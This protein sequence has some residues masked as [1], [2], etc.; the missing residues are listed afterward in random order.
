MSTRSMHRYALGSGQPAI[1][2]HNPPEIT[3]A[4]VVGLSG[5]G[6]PVADH[7]L[8]EPELLALIGGQR[9]RDRIARLMADADT[10]AD[11]ITATKARASRR[12]T[13][14]PVRQ[15]TCAECGAVFVAKGNARYCSN[16]CAARA[17]EA[18]RRERREAAK[19]GSVVRPEEPEVT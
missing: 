5:R 16:T 12:A 14:R 15:A 2:E 1:I 18:I 4:V 3:P 6:W 11:I 17:R 13:G 7:Q 8:S 9:G 10:L 19:P